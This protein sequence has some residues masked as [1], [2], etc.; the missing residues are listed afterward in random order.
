MLLELG[1]LVDSSSPSHLLAGAGQVV[2]AVRPSWAGLETRLEIVAGGMTNA[3]VSGWTAGE[4]VRNW[5]ARVRT[6]ARCAADG[7]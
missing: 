1:L 6:S 3:L 5:G 7:T 4:V 2:K